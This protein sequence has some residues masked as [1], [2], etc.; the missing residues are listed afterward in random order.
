[1]ATEKPAAQS[2]AENDYISIGEAA[3]MIGR[4]RRNARNKAEKNHILKE[5]AGHP[6]CFTE[7][8]V[9]DQRHRPRQAGASKA[10]QQH[11]QAGA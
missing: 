6:A 4:H 2:E 9:R 1:M 5:I 7:E 11:C 10:P 3:T 8:V